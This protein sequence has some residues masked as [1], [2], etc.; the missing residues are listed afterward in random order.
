MD[1]PPSDI[2]DSTE[3]CFVGEVLFLVL[4][5]CVYLFLFLIPPPPSYIYIKPYIPAAISLAATHLFRC[6]PR[7]LWPVNG[8][9]WS[10]AVSNLSSR[11][12]VVAAGM[13]LFTS[14]LHW[15]ILLVIFRKGA[16]IHRCHHF[17]NYFY[18]SLQFFHVHTLSLYNFT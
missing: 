15:N 12:T 6:D 10:Y 16:L 4:I 5:L 11:S 18:L 8:W 13:L 17:V 9:S 14:T 7:M 2:N 3:L 1:W